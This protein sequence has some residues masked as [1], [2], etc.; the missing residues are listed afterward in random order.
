M[1]LRVLHTVA[2]GHTWYGKYGYEFGRGAYNVSK[3]QWLASGNYLMTA[4][5]RHLLHD[6]EGVEPGVPAIVNRYKLPVGNAARVKDLGSLLYRLLWLQSHPE[7]ALQFF[8]GKKVGAAQAVVQRA[9]DVEA[10]KRAGTKH[11]NQQK[12]NN[13]GAMAAR[14]QP[15]TSS[16]HQK[17]LPKI[18]LGKI[19][20][21]D[22]T[23]ATASNGMKRGAG[24][25]EIDHQKIKKARTVPPPPP[26]QSPRP[27][28][29]TSYQPR[30]VIGRKVRV[31]YKGKRT[32]YHGTIEGRDAATGYVVSVVVVLEFMCIHVYLLTY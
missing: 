20:A 25:K 32:W 29:S 12:V 2:Y 19:A 5:L 17:P 1:E 24:D 23:T 15:T 8:D 26:P 30:P 13:G 31:Y 27:P 14:Q 6:F 10:A 18:K 22:S 9:D 16:Q 3:T 28:P 4:S 21:L 7:D 11:K